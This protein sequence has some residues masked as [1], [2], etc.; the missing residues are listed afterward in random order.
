MSIITNARRAPLKGAKSKYDI[1]RGV[2]YTDAEGDVVVVLGSPED[3]EPKCLV[4]YEDVDTG[5]TNFYINDA[6]NL[7]YPLKKAPRGRFVEFR[8]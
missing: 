3:S 5:T 6:N 2:V 4:F 7:T 8:N 1:E